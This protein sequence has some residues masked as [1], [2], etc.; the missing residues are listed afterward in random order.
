MI[1]QKFWEAG[2]RHRASHWI[3]RAD[4]ILPVLA[5]MPIIPGALQLHSFEMPGSLYVGRRSSVAPNRLSRCSRSSLYGD[6]TIFHSFFSTPSIAY[7][8]SNPKP[9]YPKMTLALRLHPTPSRHST[10]RVTQLAKI[11]PNMRHQARS[12][13]R[14]LHNPRYF[15]NATITLGV[16]S[17]CVTLVT[18]QHPLA[19]TRRTPVLLKTIRIRHTATGHR[20]PAACPPAS[21][22]RHPLPSHPPRHPTSAD[23][24][25]YTPNI[26]CQP[27]SFDTFCFLTHRIVI[28]RIR[29]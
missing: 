15:R 25:C 24:P 7:R 10:T 3:A 11:A 14:N 5:P 12:L 17:I 29:E 21:H 1:G 9:P 16:S 23:R 2:T 13:L 19:A 28:T 22:I 8:D 26:R 20:H 4:V 6:H 27:C 18:R